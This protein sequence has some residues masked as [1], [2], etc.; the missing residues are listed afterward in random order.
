MSTFKKEE[1]SQINNQ[2][3]HHKELEKEEQ[4]SPQNYQREKKIKMKA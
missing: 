4:M 1:R 3:L 2:T